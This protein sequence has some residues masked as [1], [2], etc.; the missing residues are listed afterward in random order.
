[1][2]IDWRFI[3]ELEGFRL[4]GYVPDVDGSNSG[5]TVAAGVDLGQLTQDGL[6]TLSPALAAK[7]QP[8]LGLTGHTAQARLDVSPLTLT[9]ADCLE[10]DEMV[11]AGEATL[12][13]AEYLKDAKADFTTLPD[14]AQTVIASVTFQYGTPWK[15]TPVFW[16]CAVRKDWHGMVR[17]LKNFGDHYATRRWKEA[18][19]LDRWLNPSGTSV[20]VA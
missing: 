16:G 1:M 11:E 2:T 20:P 19:Y 4:T 3:G 10:L 13:R 12:L 5:V 7:L 15:R 14:A 6:K 18:D 9:A 17:T 8:Y